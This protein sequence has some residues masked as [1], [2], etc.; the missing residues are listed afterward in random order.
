[1]SDWKSSQDVLAAIQRAHD[2]LRA[3]ELPVGEA[4]AAA[5]LLGG[6]VRLLDTALEHAR[7]TGR[8]EQG[9]DV[10]P[11]FRLGARSEA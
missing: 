2:A 8:L 1:M 4:H 7:L 3:G 6:A 9:S 11:E 10:L 5:R